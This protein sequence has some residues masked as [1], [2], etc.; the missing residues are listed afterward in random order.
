M[1]AGTA[2]RSHLLRNCS[3]ARS[4]RTNP[5]SPGTA[6]DGSRSHE[7]LKGTAYAAD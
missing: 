5:G 7:S 6:V 3:E 1:F 4:C 2:C